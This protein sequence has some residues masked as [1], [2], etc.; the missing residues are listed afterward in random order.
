MSVQ[1]TITRHEKL[2][3]EGVS[4]IA[5]ENILSPAVRAA[6]AGDFSGRYHSAWYGGSRHAQE[7]IEEVKELARR[8]FSCEYAFVNPLSGNICDLAAVFGLSPPK[9][10]VAMFPIAH[11]G[12][13]LDLGL[14]NRTRIDIPLVDGTYDIDPEAPRTL[15]SD[16][17]KAPDLTML[18]SSFIPFPHP[19]KSFAAA[20]V[21]PLVYDGAHVLGLIAT[22]AFQD[23]LDEGA[24]MLIGSTHKSL[25]GPQGGLVLTNDEEIADKVRPYVEFDPH[26]DIGLVD[27]PHVNRIAALGI[28]LEEI[29]DDP[30]YGQRVVRNSRALAKALDEHSTPMRF[31][32]RNYT[33]SHQI[34]MKGEPDQTDRWCKRLERTG[35]FI[36]VAGRIG[37]A[38]VTHLGMGP[39]EMEEIAEI[40]NYELHG[41]GIRPSNKDRIKA[42][43]EEFQTAFLEGKR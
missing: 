42:L 40:I 23:P 18:S 29:L 38:E 5:S 37:T 33:E 41:A 39:G 16:P 43:A 8:A 10:K 13:P 14:F 31:A 36:D 1:D 30:N 22:G 25:Y 27:N 15:F 12:Y 4:L 6:L 24:D 19:V 32:D 2:R 35:I 7:L 9:G 3:G 11:G 26:A 17:E 28:A 34:L 21:H 20:D